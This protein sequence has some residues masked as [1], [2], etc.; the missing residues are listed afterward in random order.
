MGFLG[1]IAGCEQITGTLLYSIQHDRVSHAYLLAGPEGSGK[2]A[3]ARALAIALLCSAPVK[4][5]ACGCCRS[6]RQVENHNHPDLHFLQPSGSSIKIEQIRS[7]LRRASFRSYQGGRQVFLIKQAEF[8]TVE[9]ANCLLKTL[10][11]PARDTVFILLASRPQ[12]L[13]PT[14][15]SRCQQHYL[16]LAGRGRHEAVGGAREQEGLEADIL[17]RDISNMAGPVMALEMAGQL[18]ES[19]EKAG[20][21]LNILAN[22]Y[23]DLLVWRES[24]DKSLLYSP[25]ERSELIINKAGSFETGPLLEIIEQIDITKSKILANA[26]VKLAL[27]A[28][29]LRLHQGRL[30]SKNL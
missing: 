10:E 23:R 2:E 21:A 19:R 14:V 26:N 4:G 16:T 1:E 25:E 13:L 6:C 9:A 22:W 29:F 15:L 12:A 28:L 30:N 11:E 18:S 24:G 7:V 20:A 8:M 5:D 3:L 17:I 27:E